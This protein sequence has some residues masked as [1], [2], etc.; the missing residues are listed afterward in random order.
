MRVMSYGRVISA[1]TLLKPPFEIIDQ[2]YC[3]IATAG[4]VA[5]PGVV[6]RNECLI[7]ALALTWEFQRCFE[8][9][10]N[11][12]DIDEACAVDLRGCVLGCDRKVTH[13]GNRVVGF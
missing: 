11:K 12:K 3:H 6:R 4:R 5:S 13:Q 10:V 7:V 9:R 1:A 2:L 8:P